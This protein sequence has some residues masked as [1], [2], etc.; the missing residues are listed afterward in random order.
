V[1]FR[2][3]LTQTVTEMLAGATA[4]GEIPVKVDAHAAVS[5]ILGPALRAAQRRHDRTGDHQCTGPD[6]PAGSG[7]GCEALGAA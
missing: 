2:E 4:R 6:D 7:G 5:M 3:P 1:R